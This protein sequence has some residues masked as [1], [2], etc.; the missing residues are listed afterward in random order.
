[1]ELLAGKSGLIF[2]VAN[3][4]SYAWHIAKALVE[5]GAECAFGCLPGEKNEART[6]FAADALGIADPW[7]RPC[8]VSSDQDTDTIFAEYARSFRR[9]DFVVHSVAY[10][11]REWLTPG[12]FADTPRSTFLQ[13][14]DI[15]V[16]S[17]VAMARRAREQMAAGGGGAIVSMTYYGGEKVVPG[18]NAMGVA[19]AALECSARYLANELGPFGIRVNTI[20][21]G[22]LKTLA[23]SAITGFK[24]ILTQTEKR[25]PLRRIVE[26]HDVGRTAVYLLSDLSSAVTGENVHVDCGTFTLGV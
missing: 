21:G 16:Y 18:Y 4:R 14:L 10:A 20:S 12:K 5:H 6:R 3:E 15:S 26:G 1:M 23:S 9:L 2:G 25:S 17:L 11:D 13:A 19:K 7:I 22:P 24:D 8:D